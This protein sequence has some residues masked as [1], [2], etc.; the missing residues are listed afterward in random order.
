MITLLKSLSTP[1][2]W[3]LVLS[4]ASILLLTRSHKPPLLKTGRYL[5][6]IAT[7]ILLL[8]SLSPVSN[9]LVYILENQYPPPSGDDIQNIDIVVILCGG[10][11]PAGGFRNTPEASGITYSRIFNGVDIFKNSSAGILVLSGAGGRI[12]NQSETEV[13][14]DLAMKLGIPEDKIITEPNSRNTLEHPVELA[15]L[16]PG[17]ENMRIGLVTSALHMRRSVQS[18]QEVFP[19]ENI[20]PIPVGYLYSPMKFSLESFIPR[21][22]AFAISTCAIHELIGMIWYRFL[23]AI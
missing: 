2:I 7:C 8:L 11:T 15:K 14:K 3:V 16:F 19:K 4:I 9:M 6:I 18:F 5:L 13:M 21:A 22:G 20:V 10:V 12:V 23:V 17:E 1:V